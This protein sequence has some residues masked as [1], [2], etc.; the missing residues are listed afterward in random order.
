MHNSYAKRVL[1][2]IDTS[3]RPSVRVSVNLADLSKRQKD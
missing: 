1:A 3:V 2:I